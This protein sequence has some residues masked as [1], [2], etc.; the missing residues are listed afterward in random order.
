MRIIAGLMT[1]LLIYVITLQ[2]NDPDGWLWILIYIYPT[3]LSL[4]TLLG[5]KL[6]KLHL[7]GGAAFL[8]AF[9]PYLFLVEAYNFDNEKFRESGGLLI[10]SFWLF[11]THFWIKKT[12]G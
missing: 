4:A 6:K 5:K 10:C 7:I 2:F 11:I 9:L 8:L 3:A 1:L 12:E